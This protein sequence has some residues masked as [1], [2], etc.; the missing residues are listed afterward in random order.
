MLVTGFNI[1]FADPDIAVAQRQTVFPKCCGE[2]LKPEGGG[3]EIIGSLDD[4]QVLMPE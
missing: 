2:A 1:E 3:D 4:R